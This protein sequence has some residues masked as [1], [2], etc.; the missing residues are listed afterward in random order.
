[1]PNMQAKL[2]QDNCGTQ[3]CTTVLEELSG[4]DSGL[5]QAIGAGG[6]R[7]QQAAG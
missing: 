2:V 7:A 1:M 6:E 4:R 5:A 3:Y